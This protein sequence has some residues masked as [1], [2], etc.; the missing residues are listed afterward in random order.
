MPT[1]SQTVASTIL[2]QMG[3]LGRIRAM[4]G[5]RNF[6]SYSAAAD[7]EHG[8]GLGAV[9]FQFGRGKVCR[10]TL[11]PS[12]TYSVEF[13]TTRKGYSPAIVGLYAESLRPTFERETGLYLSM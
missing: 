3:G 9:S 11:D 10:I 12:D 5:A 8:R 6:L 1:A 13:G 4:T 7:S 2:A